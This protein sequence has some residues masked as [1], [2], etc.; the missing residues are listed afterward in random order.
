MNDENDS[1]VKKPE[2][3]LV[4]EF[5]QFYKRQVEYYKKVE[6]RLKHNKD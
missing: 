4:P 1:P 3:N 5:D 6:D 2:T